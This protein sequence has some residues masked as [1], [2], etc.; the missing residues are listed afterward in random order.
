MSFGA[1][2]ALVALSVAS[3]APAEV[4]REASARNFIA[5]LA[6]GELDLATASFNAKMKDGL[7]A[8]KLDQVW[9]GVTAQFG[10]L[11]AV[12]AAARRE[13]M[14]DLDAVILACRFH[15]SRSTR[16]WP[17]DADGKIGAFLL[18]PAAGPD[19]GTPAY[20]DAKKY[21]ESA[22]TVGADGFPL[23]ATLTMPKGAGPF[24]AVVL[25]HGSGPNDRD[26]SVGGV[27]VFRDLA[28]GLA[29]RGIAVLRYEKRTKVFRRNGHLNRRSTTRTIDDAIASAKVLEKTAKIE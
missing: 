13:K 21:D 29:S 3:P 25:V 15:G 2:S 27:K 19:A 11:E 26:E 10:P 28:W 4:A 20:A 22:L 9:K 16:R 6:D 1:V 5:H 12:S 17:F 23:P 14:G 24:P 18:V 8:A 7:P